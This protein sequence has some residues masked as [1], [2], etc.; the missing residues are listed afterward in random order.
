V[1]QYIAHRE[2]RDRQILD[3]LAAGDRT[4]KELVRR[5]YTDIP[6]F[7]HAA[8]AMSVLAH[9]RKLEREGTVRRHGEEEWGR[10]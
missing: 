3:G 10:V 8:A 6:E 4:P 1:R 9:L 2:L 5:I 7:L